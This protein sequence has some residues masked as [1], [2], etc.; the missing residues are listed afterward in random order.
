MKSDFVIEDEAYRLWLLLMQTRRIMFKVRKNELFLLDVVA[1]HSAIFSMIH[2]LGKNATPAEIS[3]ILFREPHTVSAVISRLE[4]TGFVRK[5]KDLEK[6][7]M[8]RVE[9]TEKGLNAYQKGSK[10]ETIHNI[11][12][13][14]E[15][16]V[17]YIIAP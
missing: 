2:T 17:K 3:R 15:F 8:V 5:T 6:K 16:Q 7:N 10:R 11:I 12:N 13:T 1:D 9:L 4:R 14:P